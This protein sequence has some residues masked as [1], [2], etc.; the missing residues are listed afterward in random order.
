MTDDTRPVNPP[1]KRCPEPDCE[2][3]ELWTD[4]GSLYGVHGG[5]AAYAACP[6]CGP[7]PF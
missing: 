5:R 3:G 1:P 4:S 2:D 6:V 7:D